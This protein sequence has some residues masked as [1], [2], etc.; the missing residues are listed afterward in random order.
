MT[1][2]DATP[3]QLT[4]LTRLQLPEFAPVLSLLEQEK[5]RQLNLLSRADDCPLM[6]RTQGRVA[7]LRDLLDAVGQASTRLAAVHRTGRP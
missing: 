3:A 1:F 6:Y 7:M 5:T 2:F 4:A